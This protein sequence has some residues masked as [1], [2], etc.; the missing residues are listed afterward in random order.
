MNAIHDTKDPV[1]VAGDKPN[2]KAILAEYQCANSRGQAATWTS[3]QADNVRFCRWERQNAEGTKPD[4]LDAFPWP[5]A[6]DVRL[7]VAD[8]VINESEALFMN[9]FWRALA[10]MSLNAMDSAE[11]ESVAYLGK[12]LQW[13][14]RGRMRKEIWREA[15]LY[16]QWREH[17]GWVV[18]QVDWDRRI[19]NKPRDF[20]FEEVVQLAK[21]VPPNHPLAALPELIMTPGLEQQATD[22]FQ[23]LF[24]AYVKR[25][26]AGIDDSEVPEFSRKRALKAVRELRQT[27]KAR[28]P[29]PYLCKNEPCLV[30]LE[31]WVD[32]VLP[33]GA[34]DIQSCRPPFRVEWLGETE[35]RERI[36]TEGYDADW[37]EQA[38]KTAGQTDYRSV[39]RGEPTRGNVTLATAGQGGGTVL[40]GEALTNIQV[41]HAYVW[42]YDEDNV[43]SLYCTTFSPHFITDADNRP[44]YAKHE[45]LDYPHGKRPFVHG[46]REYWSR[47]L[48]A[49]RGVPEIV[50]P[51]QRIQKTQFDAAI[52]L[53]SMAVCPPWN[54]PTG[55]RYKFSPGA[56]NP[57][58]PGSKPEALQV[59]TI[60]LPVAMSLIEN[61]QKRV[62][63]YFGR[64]SP[65]VPPAR[66]QIKQQLEIQDDLIFWTEVF[67]QVL[68]LA[69][70]YM[71][72]E[73]FQRVTGAAPDPKLLSEGI[74]RLYDFFLTMDVKDLDPDAMLAK[75]KLMGEVAG[76]FDRGGVVDAAKLVKMA[77]VAIDPSLAQQLIK[78]QGEATRQLLE[79]VRNEFAQMALGNEAIYDEQPNP[80]AGMEMQ[81]AQQ[82]IQGNPQYQQRLQGDERFRELVE[83]WGKNKEQSLKQQQ[84]M[85]IGRS[86]VKPVGAGG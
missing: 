22:S 68:Q 51:Q 66:A 58:K 19:Q 46:K 50:Q 27:G 60:G 72:P 70:E 21:A 42:A 71:S 55:I 45:L 4:T 64:P 62:D 41:L 18:M 8:E 40:L 29:V 86:G 34:T 48:T 16:K 79:K 26:F 47:E 33:Q 38:I 54:V 84:N 28:V 7:Y 10:M 31:P 56:Q 73:D 12:L 23:M 59:P 6:S 2:L 85:A 35:L 83:N 53:A 30:A 5:R 49:S 15:R 81:F 43:P 80:S 11:Q 76:Q 52:D 67:E 65:D 39:Q 63:N 17:Y 57:M 75:I 14:T 24:D 74:E 69:M 25:Q 1:L 32:I 82:I 36:I 78:P 20:T 37:V 77:Y 3:D 13:L 9:G 61:S 44:S